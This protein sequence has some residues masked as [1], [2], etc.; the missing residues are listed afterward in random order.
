MQILLNGRCVYDDDIVDETTIT[1]DLRELAPHNQLTLR[2]YGKQFGEHGIYD[3]DPVTGTDRAITIHDICFNGITIGTTKM[4]QLIFE[5]HWSQHQLT[6]CSQEFK[7]Q[8]SKFE[9]NGFFGFNG[10]VTV[11]FWT[12]VMQWLGVY[13]YKVNRQANIAYFSGYDQRWHYETDLEILREIKELM[14]LD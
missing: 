4:Q 9:C 7:D 13:K 5:T 10:S 12:P 3:T 2:H 1:L 11:D 6:T 14:N 8:Y